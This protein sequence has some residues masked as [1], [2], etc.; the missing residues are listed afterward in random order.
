MSVALVVLVSFLVFQE[1]LIHFGS[2]LLLCRLYGNTLLFSLNGR[3]KSSLYGSENDNEHH[4]S[5]SQTGGTVGEMELT[6]LS[7]RTRDDGEAGVRLQHPPS[8][9]GGTNVD[10]FTVNDVEDWDS[11]SAGPSL[12]VRKQ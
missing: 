9:T 6:S 4:W 3:G 5:G 11:P 7:H 10:V 1:S 2:N 8:T 12:A